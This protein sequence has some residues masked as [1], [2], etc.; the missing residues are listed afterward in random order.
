MWLGRSRRRSHIKMMRPRK[1]GD[2]FFLELQ[3]SKME[4]RQPINRYFSQCFLQ[5]NQ[6]HLY[7]ARQNMELN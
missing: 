4:H 5:V 3:Y 2:R 7:P 6:C 1:S